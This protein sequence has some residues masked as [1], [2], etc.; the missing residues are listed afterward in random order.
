MFIIRFVINAFINVFSIILLTFIT[1]M[2][3]IGAVV[4]QIASVAA[5]PLRLQWRI[6]RGGAVGAPPI[7]Y[8]FLKN[9]PFSV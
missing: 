2:V 7:D 3:H 1:S 5:T 6:Q 8:F 4:E 9:P